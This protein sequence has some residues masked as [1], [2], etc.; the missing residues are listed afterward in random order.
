MRSAPRSTRTATLF[1]YTTFCLSIVKHVTLI[2]F[3]AQL[4]ADAVLQRK[5]HSLPNV[6]VITSA[7]TTEVLGD[8][9]RVNALTYK[10][11]KSEKSETVE[12]EGVFVQIG[13]LPNSE[14]LKDS[15]KLSPRGE[16]EVDARGQTSVPGV[17]AAGD[18]TAVPSHKILTSMTLGSTSCRE[19]RR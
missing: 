15:V 7:Q 16:I 11:R 13:L 6:R 12:L 2:E 5:L 3:D 17:F 18:V 10:D 1:P 8:G 19:R 4:R 14:W 9:Q